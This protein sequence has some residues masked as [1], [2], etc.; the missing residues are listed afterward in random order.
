MGAS[1][2]SGTLA[3]QQPSGA[4]EEYHMVRGGFPPRRCVC[5]SGTLEPLLT[6]A[7]PPPLQPLALLAPIPC[8]YALPLAPLARMRAA[9]CVVLTW[10]GRV[11]FRVGL[12]RSL[13]DRLCGEI[14]FRTFP[15]KRYVGRADR[16]TG[17]VSCVCR[18]I[19]AHS[20]C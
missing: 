15:A 18:F 5:V 14:L 1:D 13:C 10:R 19:A 11:V 8:G 17:S 3:L 4:W 6:R 9:H 12:L 16:E 7:A 2:F 20:T